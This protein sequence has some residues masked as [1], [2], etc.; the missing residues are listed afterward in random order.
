MKQTVLVLTEPRDVHAQAVALA[1]QERGAKAL[2]WYTTDF[3]GRATES[4]SFVK[5]VER[6]RLEGVSTGN[7]AHCNIATVWRRRPAHVLHSALLH[8]A[9][10]RF[11]EQECVEFRRSLLGS[12]LPKAFWVNAPDAAFRASRKILQHRTAIEVGL[13]TPD[14][15]YSNDPAEVRDFLRGHGG[16]AVYKVFRPYS[17]RDDV[18][19]W[20]PYTSL[21]TEEQLVANDLLQATPGIFQEVVQKEYELRAT[22]IGSRPFCAKLLSQDTVRGKL[23]WRKAYSEL[24]MEPYVLPH[25]IAAACKLLMARLGI[26]F[27]CFDFIVTPDGRYVFLEVNEM[28]QFLFVE[29]FA[30]LP[31]LDAFVEFLRQGHIEFV[32]DSSRVRTRYVEVENQAIALARQA[33]EEHVNLPDITVDETGSSPAELLSPSY[34]L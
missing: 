30:G 23:D 11:A 15:L 14:T 18:T 10:Q 7:L 22:V 6:T 19:A 29:Y 2:I 31:L 17:W 32:W 3:P 9:D 28:G 34:L 4:I 24:K 20:A 12:L 1:L 26:V 25:T 13:D 16:R 21:V 27:G 33:A 5:G 8:R